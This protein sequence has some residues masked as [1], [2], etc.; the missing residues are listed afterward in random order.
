VVAAALAAGTEADPAAL[1]RRLAEAVAAAEEEGRP[2]ECDL[3]TEAGRRSRLA[4]ALAAAPVRAD[5]IRFLA[6]E[7]ASAR[8]SP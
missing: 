3:A 2:V 8:Q 7:H 6:R 5:A 1:E 4:E